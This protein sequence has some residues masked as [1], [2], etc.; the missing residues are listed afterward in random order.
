[1][2]SE[3]T[4]H[5]KIERKT[6]INYI[7]KTIGIGNP[8]AT[9]ISRYEKDSLRTLTDTGVIIITNIYTKRIITMFIASI[10][11]GVAVYK[12]GKQAKQVPKNIMRTL[13]NNINY[14]DGQP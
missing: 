1:M 12:E 7:E 13:Y 14:M 3:M 2:K 4:Y 10:N 8:I 9:T 5:A 6:R 11:Q